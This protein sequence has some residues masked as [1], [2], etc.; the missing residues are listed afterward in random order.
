MQKNEL[1]SLSKLIFK[2]KADLKDQ[3]DLWIV[4][5]NIHIIKSVKK[6]LIMCNQIS[7]MEKYIVIEDPG[8]PANSQVLSLNTGYSVTANL[9]Y[10]N[11]NFLLIPRKL[12][13]KLVKLESFK[14]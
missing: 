6:L 3:F 11:D 8:V 4:E 13:E 9:F 7:F 1:E 5:H 12:A 14:K 2:K 10:E